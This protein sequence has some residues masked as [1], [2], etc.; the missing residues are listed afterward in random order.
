MSLFFN[1]IN[2]CA[3]TM[4]LNN[5]YR[6]QILGKKLYF[7][8]RFRTWLGAPDFGEKFIRVLGNGL[9]GLQNC[10]NVPWGI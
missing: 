9:I 1:K 2:P 7:F 3:L 10:L 6:M 5:I 8:M 4:H